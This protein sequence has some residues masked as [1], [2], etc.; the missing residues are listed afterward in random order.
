LIHSHVEMRYVDVCCRITCRIFWNS[1]WNT[2]A[3]AQSVDQTSLASLAPILVARCNGT[4]WYNMVHL[5]N[6]IWALYRNHPG[7][8]G[9]PWEP[10]GTMGSLAGEGMGWQFSTPGGLEFHG[11]SVGRL[12]RDFS[13]SARNFGW[14]GARRP[15]CCG[16]GVLLMWCLVLCLPSIWKCVMYCILGI[17][18]LIYN[19]L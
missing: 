19:D 9:E 10:W 6:K 2:E 1:H 18:K 4:T 5:R 7:N 15:C 16:S 12:G 14:F 17:Y 3:E 8:H 11:I 13:C